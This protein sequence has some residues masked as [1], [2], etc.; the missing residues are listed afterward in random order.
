MTSASSRRPR[1]IANERSDRVMIPGCGKVLRTMLRVV[2]WSD[3]M[4]ISLGFRAASPRSH[5]ALAGSTREMPL[6]DLVQANALARRSCDII[7]HSGEDRGISCLRTGKVLHASFVTA[8]GELTGRPAFRALM[9]RSLLEF[10]LEHS[11]TPVIENLQGDGQ[12]LLLDAAQSEDENSQSALSSCNAAA[13][14][15]SMHEAS[16]TRVGSRPMTTPEIAA[17]EPSTWVRAKR[18]VLPAHLVALG[19]VLWAATELGSETMLR[20]LDVRGLC[21]A[22][23]CRIGPTLA[24]TAAAYTIASPPLHGIHESRL[25]GAEWAVREIVSVDVG[26]GSEDVSVLELDMERVAAANVVATRQAGIDAEQVP[27]ASKFSG[28]APGRSRKLGPARSQRVN[29]WQGV[30][31][32]LVGGL[33]ILSVSSTLIYEYQLSAEDID[34]TAWNDARP[35]LRQS[36]RAELAAEAQMAGW[37]DAATDAFVDCVVDAAID[38]LNH[39]GCR[40]KYVTST[41][42]REEHL[43]DQD[44]CVARLGIEQRYEAW[45]KMCAFKNTRVIAP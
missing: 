45:G 3:S 20:A 41:S 21:E 44:A 9:A 12:L 13:S 2:P 18:R 35:E 24:E 11:E 37:S 22:D 30:L 16:S 36:M 33:G 39:S 17:F 34:K 26:D 43:R 14:A 31:G 27:G 23:S 6:P 4:R 38:F 29:P 25:L 32:M 15:D 7:V 10:R 1:Y 40:Y 5:M 19:L 42:S 28:A 8:E